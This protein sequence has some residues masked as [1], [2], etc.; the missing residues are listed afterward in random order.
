[1]SEEKKFDV[2]IIGGGVNGCGIARDLAGRGASV[3]LAEQHD[4]ASGTSS[5]STKLIHGGLRYL[6]HYE[7]SLVREALKEREVLL[8]LAPHIVTPM[9]FVLPHHKGLRS[10]WLIRLGLLLYDNLGGRKLL[11]RSRGLNLARDEAGEALKDQFTRGFEYSD[12]WVDDARLV[13]LNAVG[14]AA[15]GADVRVRTRVTRAV[16]E[17][18]HWS[19]T[20]TDRDAETTATAAARVLINAAGPWVAEVLARAI[21]GNTASQVRL[22]KGSHIVVPR[23]FAHDR[24]YICQNTDNRVVFAIP[25]QHDYTLIGTTD[26]DYTGDPAAAAITA[27]ETAYLCKLASEYF[28]APVAPADVVWSYA[29]VRPLY[30]DPDQSAQE[31]SRDYV[32]ELTEG[33]PALLNI[34]GGKITTYRKLAEA[35]AAKLA[36]VLPGLGPA[37]TDAAPLPGGDFA[38]D[39][40]GALR[41]ELEAQCGDLAPAVA[42]RLVGAYGTRALEVVDGAT[43]TTELGRDFGGGLY[44]AEVAYLMDR[45]W[46]RTAD[47]VLWRRSKLGLRLSDDQAAQLD[48]WMAARAKIAA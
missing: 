10:A 37:W 12:C 26:L 4:L 33:P 5:A 45:E 34:I 36:G 41:R 1:M 27:D 48:G 31:L 42:A 32:L 14:A 11:P 2:A 25:Y 7:F 16:R 9:R 18:D 38:V 46:A 44:E 21:G 28:K 39:G 19:L 20:L 40:A 47:D 35:A 8:R 30:G 17:G 3:L 6:E 29:G 22:V 23:M 13:A 43:T 15:L 24:A